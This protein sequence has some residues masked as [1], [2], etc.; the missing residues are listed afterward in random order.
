MDY[1]SNGTKPKH[2]RVKQFAIGFV[3]R[4]E[5]SSLKG[6]LS[7]DV[8]ELVVHFYRGDRSS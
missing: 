8:Y 4:A 3:I 6:K 2:L 7:G 1:D 5:V